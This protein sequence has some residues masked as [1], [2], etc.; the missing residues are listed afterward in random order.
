ML[1][2]LVSVNV[3]PLVFLT[4]ANVKADAFETFVKISFEVVQ[5]ASFEA[6]SVG[7]RTSLANCGIIGGGD[8]RPGRSF[9]SQRRSERGSVICNIRDST[10]QV[11]ASQKTKAGS[12]T[13]LLTCNFASGHQAHTHHD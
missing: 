13:Y 10:K 5:Q 6:S 1:L 4:G 7:Y 8:I 2:P 9:C 11:S 12:K 3:A